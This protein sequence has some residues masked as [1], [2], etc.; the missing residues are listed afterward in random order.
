MS[1]T[2]TTQEDDVLDAIVYRHYGRHQGTTEAVLE[3]NRGLASY[4]LVLPA[5]LTITLPD[6]EADQPVQS[7]K[8]YD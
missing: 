6:I 2:Y 8:L 7:V 3:A 1:N 5:G 4:G